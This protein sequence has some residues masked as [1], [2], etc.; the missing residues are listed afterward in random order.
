MPTMGTLGLGQLLQ[1]AHA[2]RVVALR[3]EVAELAR[4][5]VADDAAADAVVVRVQH[6]HLMDVGEAYLHVA[7]MVD[8]RIERRGSEALELALDAGE[9]VL[10][11]APDEHR[12]VVLRLML[13]L[14]RLRRLEPVM[15]Q[16]GRG[17]Q[18]VLPLGIQEA[19]DEVLRDIRGLRP[20]HPRG[21]LHALEEPGE[22]VRVP[23]RQVALQQLVAHQA[24]GPVHKGVLVGQEEDHDGAHRPHVHLVVV[25]GAPARQEVHLGR[26]EGGR[27]D[28][29]R[30]EPVPRQLHR[31]AEVSELHL[32]PLACGLS[33][34]HCV[35]GLDVPVADGLPV[36]VREALE[37]LPDEAG[38]LPL[39]QL[40]LAVLGRVLQVSAVAELQHEEELRRGVD[41]VEELDELGLAP[42]LLHEVDLG[43]DQVVRDLHLLH[44]PLV[45]GLDRA[46]L[47]ILQLGRPDSAEGPLSQRFSALED[48]ARVL[49]PLAV[50]G[51]EDVEA[52][53]RPAGRRGRSQ[54]DHGGAPHLAV[55]R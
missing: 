15:L 42:A 30:L 19:P 14:L 5:V 45:Q 47:P 49:E 38:H 17:P 44:P 28:L 25:A 12:R 51:C 39:A 27:A 10:E 40:A 48:L 16:G 36:Q 43:L 21:L 26:H 32:R 3:A 55:F 13:H 50:E 29:L 34:D 9:A 31:D 8:G 46:H 41:K 23:D 53:A 35:L 33:E 24:A 4:G 11:V 6:G 1:A 37:H 18:P 20:L 7:D 22:D 54:G 52:D 2:D